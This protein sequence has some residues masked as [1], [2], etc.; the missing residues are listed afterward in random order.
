MALEY[1]LKA[2]GVTPGSANVFVDT[3]AMFLAKPEEVRVYGMKTTEGVVE[4]LRA[5]GRVQKKIDHYQEFIRAYRGSA[6]LDSDIMF[7]RQFDGC[8][9]YQRA[10][11][12]LGAMK[13]DGGIIEDSD[14]VNALS[15]L[16]VLGAKYIVATTAR[17]YNQV[18]LGTEDRN[19]SAAQAFL[20]ETAIDV[21]RS[22]IRKLGLDRNPSY[23]L[24]RDAREDSIERHFSHLMAD[25][26]VSPENAK[27]RVK[28]LIHEWEV[29]YRFIQAMFT[30]DPKRKEEGRM[31][32]IISR[33]VD[34]VGMFTDL[35]LSWPELAETI[36]VFTPLKSTR[37]RY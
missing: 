7:D 5:W 14:P 15:G 37:R 4:E 23:N 3:N 11:E 36:R 24:I 31:N 6:A 9:R 8:M 25:R 10:I 35:S 13:A 17:S 22:G 27:A 18:V 33:D 12:A 19:R 2:T 29:D 32:L 21:Y 1:M 16:W 30:Y 34:L 28:R 20:V 26:K